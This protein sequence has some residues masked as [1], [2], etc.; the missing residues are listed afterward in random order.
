VNTDGDWIAAGFVL[1]I[2]HLPGVRYARV[3]VVSPLAA[4]FPPANVAELHHSGSS[5]P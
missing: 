1:K 5:P 4:T 3:R 2:A